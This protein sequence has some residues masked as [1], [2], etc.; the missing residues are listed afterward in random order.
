MDCIVCGVAR[1]DTTERLPHHWLR[2]SAFIG[3]SQRTKIPQALQS[4]KKGAM[5]EDT[6]G[7]ALA[8]R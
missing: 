3:E 1:S 5:G 6:K 8:Q 2:L 4:R 7:P